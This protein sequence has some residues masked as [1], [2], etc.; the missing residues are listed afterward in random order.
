LRFAYT[1][2]GGTTLIF[3]SI[4]VEGKEVRRNAYLIRF[5]LSFFAHISTIVLL[6][7]QYPF[8][9]R[10]S[11]CTNLALSLISQDQRTQFIKSN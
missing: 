4:L 7:L 3:I 8:L 2:A 10:K 9:N 5:P 11:P 1:Q 6:C